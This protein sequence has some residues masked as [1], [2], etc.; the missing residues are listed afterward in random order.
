MIYI[1]TSMRLAM[2]PQKRKVNRAPRSIKMRVAFA[3][4][5]LLA[6]V[7][8]LNAQ[9]RSI[10]KLTIGM[11]IRIIVRIQSPTLTTEWLRVYCSCISMTVSL[12]G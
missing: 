1:P 5:D 7:L 6:G 11:S 3:Q 10:M 4:L 8:L 9:T 12:K 2:E